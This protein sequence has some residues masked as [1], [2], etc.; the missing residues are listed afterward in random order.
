MD[1]LDSSLPLA[2]G[3]AAADA[4]AAVGVS[5]CSPAAG[6]ALLD[7]GLLGLLL[8]LEPTADVVAAAAAVVTAAV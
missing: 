7:V 2:S 4:S 1:R 3:A 6:W 8:L 5:C